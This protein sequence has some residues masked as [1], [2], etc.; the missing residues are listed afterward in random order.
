MTNGSNTDTDPNTEKDVF[1]RVSARAWGQTLGVFGYWSADIYDNALREAHNVSE[2]ETQ[3]ESAGMM[4]YDA[5]EELDSVVEAI[6]TIYDYPTAGDAYA[7]LRPKLDAIRSKIMS[8]N[9][10]FQNIVKALKAIES[11]NP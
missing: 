9:E 1:G 4:L 10:T 6:P 7:V 2:Q 3:L 5:S 8:V 11:T